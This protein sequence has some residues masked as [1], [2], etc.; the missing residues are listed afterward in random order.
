MFED[1]TSDK[2]PDK[3]GD[4]MLHVG[5]ALAFVLFGLDKFP[6]GADAQWVK[7]FNQ[8]G[9]G[10]WFRY[11]TGIVEVTGGALVLIPVTARVGLAILA[12]TMAVAS[13]I[14]IFVIRQPANAIITGGL[15]VGLAA[16]WWRS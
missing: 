7:F 3:I 14:H 6:S 16:F 5:I 8:V 2:A 4:W 1:V 11:L 15:C 9:V 13:A 12:T 10:Q